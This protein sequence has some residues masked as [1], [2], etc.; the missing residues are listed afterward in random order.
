MG[1]QSVKTGILLAA[2][3][4]SSLLGEKALARFAE[5]TRRAFPG[6]PVRWAYTSD[7]MRSRLAAAGKKTDS[8]KKAL[9]RMGFERYSHVAVQSLHLIPG[10]EYE[11][12]LEET[13]AARRQGGPGHISVGLPLLHDA[14]DVSAASAA[15]L[16]HLPEERL[17]HEPVICMGHGTWHMGAASYAALAKAVSKNDERIFIG[18]LEGDHRIEKLLPV[19]VAACPPVGAGPFSGPPAEA[20]APSCP[21]DSVDFPEGARRRVW[22]LPLLSVIGKHA[23]RDM[24]GDNPDSWRSLIEGA[25]YACRPILTGT[26]EY[27]EFARIWLEH[28]RVA[29][30]DLAGPIAR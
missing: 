20:G 13:E 25:G 4:S 24:A 26:A 18:A 23:E 22:L 7:R 6:T 21:A 17:P 10:V 15:L 8:V 27:E 29:L 2:F 1:G 9:C 30:A 16:A 28:L 11:A 12:L 14:R 5:R 3:G 19:V